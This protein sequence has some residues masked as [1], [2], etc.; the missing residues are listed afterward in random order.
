MYW[1]VYVPN[2]SIDLTCGQGVLDNLNGNNCAP[3]NWQCYKDDDSDPN[4]GAWMYFTAV[5]G[6]REAT[7]HSVLAAA[8]TGQGHDW[9]QD[10]VCGPEP[11]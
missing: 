8:G 7:L 5:N 3:T 4:S 6:C 9:Y 10:V 2:D 1:G 11:S